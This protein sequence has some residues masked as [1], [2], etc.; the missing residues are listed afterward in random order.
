MVSIYNND[1]LSEL[2][3]LNP[4]RNII[5]TLTLSELKQTLDEVLKKE[6]NQPDP[7]DECDKGDESDGLESDGLD[8]DE[9]DYKKFLE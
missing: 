2:F 6:D 9:T 7:V 8:E 1:L 4:C 5:E 3:K